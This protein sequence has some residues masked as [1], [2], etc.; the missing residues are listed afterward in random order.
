MLGMESRVRAD[1]GTQFFLP[2]G[3]L[4]FLQADGRLGCWMDWMIHIADDLTIFSYMSLDL[5]VHGY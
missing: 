5:V 3:R 4:R 1:G 2:D